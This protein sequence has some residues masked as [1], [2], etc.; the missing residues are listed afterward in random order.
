MGKENKKSDNS[1]INSEVWNISKSYVNEMVLRYLILTNNYYDLARFGYSNIE[2]DVFVRD[3]NL[4]N[5]A[6]LHALRRL[7]HTIRVLIRNTK[8]TINKDDKLIFSKYSIRLKKLDDNISNLRLEQKRGSRVMELNINEEL[9]D[10][11]DS[12]ISDMIDDITDK[13]NKAGLIFSQGE[14]KD[15]DVLKDGYKKRFLTRT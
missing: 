2:S 8:F 4:K 1:E 15:I 11:M 13:L 3:N 9:F 6:R 10:K 5:T 12:E 7:F 14:E